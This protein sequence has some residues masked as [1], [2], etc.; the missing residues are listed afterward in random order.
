VARVGSADDAGMSSA[1]KVAAV[2]LGAIVK[3]A[4]KR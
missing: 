4:R 1:V 2:V 3:E